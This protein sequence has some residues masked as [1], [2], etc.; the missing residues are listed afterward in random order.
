MSLDDK[1]KVPLGEPGYPVASV[2]RG[3]KVLVFVEKSFIVGDH[4]FTRSS[5][6]PSGALFI[7]VPQSINGLFYHGKC[8]L[9]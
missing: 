3:K 9:E 8:V 1:H 7:D 5:L 2:E 4:D 6:T